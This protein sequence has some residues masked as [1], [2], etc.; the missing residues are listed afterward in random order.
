MHGGGES[1]LLVS[2]DPDI[3]HQLPRVVTLAEINRASSAAKAPAAGVVRPSHGRGDSRMN[4][5]QLI[6]KQMR[7][8]SLSTWLTMLSVCSA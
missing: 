8:R 3:A 6:F 5:F 1:L 2:H 4:F 7:Q